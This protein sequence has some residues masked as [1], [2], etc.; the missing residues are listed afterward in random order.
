MNL[1]TKGEYASRAVLDLALR[2]EQGPAKI[3]EIARRQHIP[4]KYLEQVLLA[5]KSAGLVYSVRGRDGGYQLA[6][7]PEEITLGEI[8]RA[9][10]GPLAP[11]SCVSQTAYRPC[12]CPDETTCA[13]RM[14]WL[15]VRNAIADVLDRTSMA[16]IC[17]QCEQLQMQRAPAYMYY[18]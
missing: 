9:T 6:R 18:I 13:L 2:Y 7:P 10:D 1:T 14:V 8:I 5:L 15:E 12:T 16:A 11:I 17:Q 4:K 3:E